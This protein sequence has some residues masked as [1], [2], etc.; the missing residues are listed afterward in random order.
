MK[1]RAFGRMPQWVRLSEVLGVAEPNAT[2]GHNLERSRLKATNLAK[3]Y[4]SAALLL[5]DAP[6]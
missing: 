2:R 5:T 4:F 1:W 6:V 3:G